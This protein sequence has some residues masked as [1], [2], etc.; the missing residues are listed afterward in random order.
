[1]KPSSRNRG[2]KKLGGSQFLVNI[3]YFQNS[4]WQG[5]I[6]RLDTGETISFRSGIELITLMESAISD[7]RKRSGDESTLRKWT[8]NTREVEKGKHQSSAPLEN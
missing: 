1:M 8:G 5:S 3:R 4:S 6:Q 2:S 7:Q